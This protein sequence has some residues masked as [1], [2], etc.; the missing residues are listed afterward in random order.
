[1]P[2]PVIDIIIPVYNAY[3][4]LQRCLDSV[5]RTAASPC[6]LIL[7]DDCSPDSRIAG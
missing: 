5:L 1:M 7:L 2:Q 6:R 3:D 4:D